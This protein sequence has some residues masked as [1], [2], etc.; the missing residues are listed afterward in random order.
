MGRFEQRWGRVCAVVLKFSSSDNDR[1]REVEGRAEKSISTGISPPRGSD[2][3][4]PKPECTAY[5]QA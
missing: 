3:R 2:I 4:S 5:T 1:A